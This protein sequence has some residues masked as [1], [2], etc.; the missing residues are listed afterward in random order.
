MV[1]RSS[2]IY[3]NIAACGYSLG[4]GSFSSKLPPLL[5]IFHSN[6]IDDLSSLALV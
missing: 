3:H 5:T 1:L 6:V 2:Q 4:T